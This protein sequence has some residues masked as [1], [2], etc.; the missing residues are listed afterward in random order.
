MLAG[1]TGGIESAYALRLLDRL[2]AAGYRAALLNY[3]GRSG[4][5]NRRPI[6]YHA[7]FTDDLDL[8]A[9]TLAADSGPG[10]VAG[11][12]MGGNLLLKWLGER[13]AEAP[14]KAAAAASVPFE[15]E[16]AA[17]S[18][19]RGGARY[20]DR[21]L[22]GGLKRY[23][24]RKFVALAL[25]HR[26]PALEK[27]ANIMQFD[28]L[29]TAPLHGFAGASDYYMQASCRFWL[30]HIRVPTL[31]VNAIDDPLIPSATLPTAQELAPC[32]TLEVSD[33][34]GHVGFLGRGSAGLPRHWL[35][36]RL[37]EFLLGHDRTPA[38][39]SHSG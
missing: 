6:G 12:S 33:R 25:P 3:R 5:P 14:V 15:L 32:V 16:P 17:F 29:I 37:A 26:L 19:Q 10:L 35:D 34:G 39:V 20:Y 18:L 38:G 30:R 27:I 28:D 22:L 21:Y 11:Y 2:A 36:H 7:G 13:G 9:R 4:T 24:R 8:V 31:V 1:L 23:V